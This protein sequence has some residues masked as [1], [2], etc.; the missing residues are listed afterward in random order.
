MGKGE[1]FSTIAQNQWDNFN[2]KLSNSESLHEVSHRVVSCF[3]EITE[4]SQ[5]SIIVVSHGTAL[6]VQM[7]VLTK[8]S[9]LIKIS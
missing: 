1:E 6:S 2:Y 8:N 9:L 4:Q 5:A 3:K 7:N